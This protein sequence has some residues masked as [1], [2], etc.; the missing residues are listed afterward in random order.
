MFVMT[1]VCDDLTTVT[2]SLHRLTPFR[3]VGHAR[4]FNRISIETLTEVVGELARQNPS[5][6][7]NE[8]LSWKTE[9]GSIEPLATLLELFT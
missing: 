2:S 5:L 6:D 1:E 9:E 3:L 8:L 4:Y 7:K